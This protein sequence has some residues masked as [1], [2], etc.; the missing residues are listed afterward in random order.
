MEAL[1]CRHIRKIREHDAYKD[2]LIVVVVENN[3]TKLEPRRIASHLREHFGNLKNIE[4]LHSDATKTGVRTQDIQK[5]DFARTLQNVLANGHLRFVDDYGAIS[6]DWK[7][8][9]AKLMGQL[10][11]FRKVHRRAQL[12]GF[13]LDKFGYT[14]KAS[15]QPDDAALTLQLITSWHQKARA[16]PQFAAQCAAAGRRF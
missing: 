2:A 1:Y 16:D 10:R 13:N 15:G 12:D 6:E 8:E 9:K 14:G 11:V 5:E 4:F 3:M 7:R